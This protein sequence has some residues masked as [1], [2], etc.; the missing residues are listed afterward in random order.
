MLDS[1]RKLRFK[2]ERFTEVAFKD[3]YDNF[4]TLLASVRSG[5]AEVCRPDTLRPFTVGQLLDLGKRVAADYDANLK[6]DKTLLEPLFAD[7]TDTQVWV[8]KPEAGAESADTLE[9]GGPSESQPEE[10]LQEAE[11]TGL[12][13]AVPAQLEE[14]ESLTE[15]DLH[16]KSRNELNELAETLGIEDPEKLPNK[17]AVIDEIIACSEAQE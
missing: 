3:F 14:E 10:P 12:L 11:E 2:G 16:K 9:V 5:T 6:V 7:L 8:E 13:S 1:G 15:E 4:N 17:Q